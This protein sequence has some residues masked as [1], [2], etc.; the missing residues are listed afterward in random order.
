MLVNGK[1]DSNN[2]KEEEKINKDVIIFSD[3]VKKEINLN[4]NENE[5]NFIF[6]EENNKISII[7]T[8]SKNFIP[9]KSKNIIEILKKENSQINEN[10]KNSKI[11][12]KNKY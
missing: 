12:F 1:K 3:M 5:E 4:L 9:L 7:S 11:F 10:N 2:F 8:N 6:N